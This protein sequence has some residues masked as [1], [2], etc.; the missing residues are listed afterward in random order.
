MSDN[1]QPI[2]TA[3]ED[4]AVLVYGFG[5]EVAHFNTAL[6]QWVA[7]YDHRPLNHPEW[8]QPLPEAPR[9]VKPVSQT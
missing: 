3:P 1:W 6:K 9:A 8:W 2:E 7:C 5:Y 4:T